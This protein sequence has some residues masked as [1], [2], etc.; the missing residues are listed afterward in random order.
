MDARFGQAAWL[1]LTG[2]RAVPIDVGYYGMYGAH[3][4]SSLQRLRPALPDAVVEAVAALLESPDTRLLAARPAVTGVTRAFAY[5]GA[6]VRTARLALPVGP[7]D[8][9]VSSFEAW[10]AWFFALRHSAVRAL[11]RDYVA[12]PEL[13]MLIHPLELLDDILKLRARALSRVG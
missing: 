12:K 4:F 10:R 11:I 2:F 8:A 9:R 6:S 13:R 5:A 7:H 3:H 1:Q